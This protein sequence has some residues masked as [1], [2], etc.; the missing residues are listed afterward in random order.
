[1]PAAEEHELRRR[2]ASD[3]LASS[4]KR[5]FVAAYNP[6]ARQVNRRTWSANEI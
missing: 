1:M 6:L 5:R 4:A 3:A 2:P